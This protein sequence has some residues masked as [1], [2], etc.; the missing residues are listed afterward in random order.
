MVA[1]EAA[2]PAA[3]ALPPLRAQLAASL[4][5]LGERDE[6]VEELAA[7]CSSLRALVQ[8]QALALTQPPLALTQPPQ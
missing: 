7:D 2:R 5:L 4:Q 8:Q 3:A 1:L 6:R